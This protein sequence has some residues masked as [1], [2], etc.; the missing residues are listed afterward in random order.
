M[1]STRT[2]QSMGFLKE[3]GTAANHL[4]ARHVPL[5]PEKIHKGGSVQ[6][7]R[8]FCDEMDFSGRCATTKT[9][10][11]IMKM[12]EKHSNSLNAQS[13]NMP[14]DSICKGVKVTL[15]NNSMWN[16]YFRC[17]TEMILTKQGCRMFPYCRFRISG[18]Q[19]HRKYSLIMDIQPLDNNQ[20]I[21]TGEGWQTSRKA[22]CHIKSK[23]FIHPESPATGQHWMQSPVSFYKLKLTNNLSYQEENIILHPLH[24]YL[25][26]LHLVEMDKATDIIR[27]ND[28]NVL[29]FSFRQTEFITVTTYQNPQFAQLKVNY[30]PFAKGLKEGG[31]NSWGLKLKANIG[32]DV[33][34]DG[35]DSVSEQHPVKKSLKILLENH[36][37]KCSKEGVSRFSIDHQKNS[38][39]NNDPCSAAVP[40]ETPS[41][42]HPAQK[43]IS[44]LIREAHVSLRRCPVEQLDSDQSSSLSA[45]QSNTKATSSTEGKKLGVGERDSTSPSTPRKQ[46]PTGERHRK[47]KDGKHHLNMEP[48]CCSTAP[49]EVG[50]VFSEYSDHQHVSATASDTVKQQ[51]RPARLP[52]PALALF[53]KQH[54][55]KYKKTN[56][57]M[58]SPTQAPP[59]ESPPKSKDAIAAP[60]LEAIVRNTTEC[61]SAHPDQIDLDGTEQAGEAAEQSSSQ[62]SHNSI[63]ASYSVDTKT[64]DPLAFAPEGLGSELKVPDDKPVTTNFHDS[65]SPPS[66]STCSTSFPVSHS[67]PH[68]VLSAPNSPKTAVESSDPLKSEPLLFYSECSFDFGPLSLASSPEPLPSLPACLGLDTESS[69]A[70]A[71]TNDSVKDPEHSKSTSVLKWHTVLPPPETNVQSLFTFHSPHQVSPL[72]SVTPPLFPRHLQPPSLNSTPTS[73]NGSTQSFQETEPPLPFPGELSPL[74]LQL[75]LSPTFSSLDENG[76]SPTPSLSDLVHLFTTDVD[77]GMGVEFANTEPTSA[78]CPSP[79]VAEI[80]EASSQMLQVPVGKPCTKKKASKSTKLARLDMDQSLDDYRSKQPN[81]D[82]VEEQLFISF[83]SKE[84]LRIHIADSCGDLN[85][86]PRILPE[87]KQ[88]DEKPKLSNDADC[89]KETIAAFQKNL[90]KDLDLMKYRQVIH[91]VLQ[92]VGLKMTLLDP[93]LSIDLQYLGVCLPIPPPGTDVEPQTRTLPPSQGGSSTFL[94][95]TGKTTDVTQI[96]GWREKFTSSTTLPISESGPEAPTGPQLSGSTPQLGVPSSEPQKKNLS[97]FCSDMLDEY[98]ENEGKLIDERAASFSQPPVETPVYKLPKISSSYVRTL[99]HIQTN[100]TTVSPASDLISG[101]IPPSKRPRLSETKID[102]RTEK[103]LRGPKRNKSKPALSESSPC[104]LQQPVVLTPGGLSQPIK[105]VKQPPVARRRKLKHITSSHILSHSGSIAVVSDMHRDLAPVESDSELEQTSGPSVNAG[106][107]ESQPTVTRALLRQKELENGVVWEGCDPTSITKE[108]AAIA[109][110][111]LFTQT[112]FVSEDPTAPVQLPQKRAL[113]CQNDFC[114][115]GCVCSSLSYNPRI[116]HC[117]RPPCMFGC[118]CLKQK[119]VLL[120]NLDSSDSSTPSH[121]DKAKKRKK[122]KKKKKK[123]RMKMAYVLKEADSVTQSVKRVRT[124]WRRNVEDTDPEPTYN[125]VIALPS[126]SPAV[127]SK[128]R[129]LHS[130]CARVQCFRGKTL[131]QKEA[132][133]DARLTR[134][135]TLKQQELTSKGTETKTS[136]SPSSTKKAQQDQ[137]SLVKSTQNPPA[138]RTPKPARRLFIMAD[139]KWDCNEDRSLVLKKL[140][141]LMARE[142]LDKWF[143]FKKYLISP[144]NKTLVKTGFR[145]YI[146]YTVQVSA[147]SLKKKQDAVP[148][149]EA[150]KGNQKNVKSSTLHEQDYPSKPTPGDE[151]SPKDCRKK[152]QKPEYIEDWQI[153]VTEDTQ[154]VEDWQKEVTEETQVIEDWQK[155]VTEETQPV[156]DWQKEVTEETQPVQDWQKEA[157]VETQPLQDWQKEATVET[158][159]LQDWQKEAT[160]ETQP[161]QDWQKEATVETQ[162]LQDWQK[163]ATVEIQP[164]QD[165]QKEATVE[166][167]PLQDWQKEATVETQP[168]QDWQ[169]E[170]TVETQP[171]QDWQKEATVE[172]QPLQDWQKEATVE[173]QPLQDWQKEATE[174][175]QPLQDWQKEVTEATQVIKDWQK[176]VTVETQPLQDWQKEVTV[177]TQPLQD[178]QKEVT[179]ETQPVQ[180]IQKE[181]TEETQLVEDWEKEVLEEEQLVEDWQKEVIEETDVLEDWQKEV[182]KSEMKEESQCHS[183][184]KDERQER[185]AKMKSN[186]KKIEG[187]ALPS[188]KKV[189]PAG[190]LPANRKHPGGTDHLIQV[191]GKLYPLANIHVDGMGAS[192]PANHL[193]TFLTGHV[194]SQSQS[195]VSSKAPNS[196]PAPITALSASSD[197]AASTPTITTTSTPPSVTQ[198]TFTTSPTALQAKNLVF[199]TSALS[200]GAGPAKDAPVMLVRV[201]P[202]QIPQEVP[203]RLLSSQQMVLQPVQTAPSAQYYRQADGKLVQLIAINQLRPIKSKFVVKGGTSSSSALSTLCLKTPAVTTTRK[204]PTGTTG[205][206]SSS[207]SSSVPYSSCPY[208]FYSPS[209]LSSIPSS[210]TSSSTSLPSTFVSVAKQG[211]C[212]FKLQTSSSSKDSP[213]V[214][215]PLAQMGK[216]P[217]RRPPPQDLTKEVKLPGHAVVQHTPASPQTQPPAESPIP[218]EL[219]APTLS[220]SPERPNQNEDLAVNLVD[221]DIICVDDDTEGFVT[222]PR[223]VEVVNLVSSSETENSSDTETEEEEKSPDCN[224]HHHNMMEKMRRWQLRSHFSD[225]QKEVGQSPKMSK[226]FTLTKAVSLIQ[227]LRRTERTLKRKKGYLKK[228][229]DTFLS[230]LASSEEQTGPVLENSD[231]SHCTNIISSDE[232][233]STNA[234]PTQ[235]SFTEVPQEI[236]VLQRDGSPTQLSPKRHVQ[237]EPSGLENMQLSLTKPELEDRPAASESAEGGACADSPVASPDQVC[238]TLAPPSQAMGLSNSGEEKT[239]VIKRHRTIPI[240]LSRAKKASQQVPLNRKDPE[241]ER[242]LTDGDS[243][244]PAEVP[245]LP[246]KALPEKPVLHLSPVAA[247]T[248]YLRAAPPPPPPP[249]PGANTPCLTRLEI[250]DTSLVHQSKSGHHRKTALLSIT[251]VTGSTHPPNPFRPGPALHQTQPTVQLTQNLILRPASSQAPGSSPQQDPN[252][253]TN[254]SSL[255]SNGS[256]QQSDVL[257]VPAPVELSEQTFSVLGKVTELRHAPQSQAANIKSVSDTS[258]WGVKSGPTVE[259]TNGGVLAPPPLLHMKAGQAKVVDLPSSEGTAVEGGESGVGNGGVTWRPMPRL[260]PLGLRGNSPS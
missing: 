143:W 204:S 73:P 175:T 237:M 94:S 226:V 187:I 142:Q 180:D 176:E 184:Y 57:K 85:S 50:Q 107:R 51:K 54:S 259:C 99:D 116:S 246:A 4:P 24:R 133:N 105:S 196:G 90:L 191:N 121:H 219:P 166:T 52:L 86:Q 41:N 249:P 183:K 245:S 69:S 140:C 122:K 18:L 251:D 3:G 223:P 102:R 193:V 10:E 207:S 222:I 101:F 104:V 199:Q 126:S 168:L 159:P 110:T 79:T 145:P 162:P 82:E 91:P 157:T 131:K 221:L 2:H 109:L 161:L 171:L 173:T 247:E 160:V 108:R 49:S 163:E 244:A 29:T 248:M 129:S 58:T 33:N 84:A 240:I 5:K 206:L 136:D 152:V 44:E 189:S 241:G 14:P 132:S 36:K 138:E 25:P 111:S 87:E 22:E 97:A 70:A 11:A 151:R 169:K 63:M 38:T 46:S 234:E 81:L 258:N 26:R 197:P 134:Q 71:A 65:F 1:A 124:L 12:S 238:V 117:G 40:K 257:M 115:L 200:V 74:T 242:A 47:L 185:S 218:E 225:L 30:N 224:R 231:P 149:K 61:S 179:V 192:H 229:R 255:S 53:L 220:P 205:T 164:L 181:V 213:Q 178:W 228:R 60:H 21:W 89:V 45:P 28:P 150:T 20:Y 156:E 154:P 100:K 6:S 118:S 32:K 186:K 72:M 148:E 114:R 62:L 201:A 194:G 66:L 42:S 144:I 190:Y 13:E 230:I 167:Q 78:P 67:L 172:I 37:P 250:P 96:K 119:V 211:S 198:H 137:G 243:Q 112:G 208:S 210:N 7:S 203:A 27:L 125:P 177:E 135:K 239:P 34:K 31:L 59:T 236:Q 232:E 95:R 128:R 48:N 254:S 17:R 39:K 215:V 141:R 103:K 64:D 43:L 214:T 9:K 155:E 212:T 209:S 130:S 227:K 98:L 76:L 195:Y 217:D 19:P 113:P 120:K 174:A 158:Q 252:S 55:T 165:W 56:G 147:P 127:K 83:T 75:S 93:A 123:R 68:T 253:R 15:D 8:E 260:V 16:E 202:S 188:L 235:T 106:K 146:Q 170:A 182:K 216:V 77:I 35:S 88:T 80:Q 233:K 153:E 92:E 256:N 23:P 139:C